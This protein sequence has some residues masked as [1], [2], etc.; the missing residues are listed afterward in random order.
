MN[1]LW[2]RDFDYIYKGI[3]LTRL[4]SFL[5]LVYTAITINAYFTNQSIVVE[6]E[7]LTGVLIFIFVFGKIVDTLKTILQL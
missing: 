6:W 5:L 1:K 7:V 2:W 3:Y 4:L